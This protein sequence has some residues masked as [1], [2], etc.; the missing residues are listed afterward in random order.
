MW[1][2]G[3]WAR[4][5]RHGGGTAAQI[6]TKLGGVKDP[7]QRMRHAKNHA[8]RISSCQDMVKNAKKQRIDRGL[9]NSARI[10]MVEGAKWRRWRRGYVCKRASGRDN[11]LLRYG[12]CCIVH[13][14]NCSKYRIACS[15]RKWQRIRTV[16]DRLESDGWDEFRDIK[17][18]RNGQVDG[19]QWAAGNQQYSQQTVLNTECAAAR[20]KRD[21]SG[22]NSEGLEYST[23]RSER[24]QKRTK[25]F[26]GCGDK[27]R[28]SRKLIR[29]W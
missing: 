12:D 6:K 17:I 19:T 20:R 29:H 5:N 4:R 18:A 22:W 9:V 15:G 10:A 21:G 7:I 14:T 13:S 11:G 2:K 23:R 8:D 16:E 28:L 25:R 1:S 24:A 26:G 3:Q 27:R